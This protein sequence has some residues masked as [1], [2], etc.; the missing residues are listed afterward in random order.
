M[1]GG[2]GKGNRVPQ[3]S[4]ATAPPEAAL[5]QPPLPCRHT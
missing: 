5:V 3:A 4:T 1:W 2:G